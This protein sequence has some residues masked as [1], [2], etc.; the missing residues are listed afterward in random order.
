MSDLPGKTILHYKILEHVGQ[1]GMGVVYK[2]KDTKLDREVA[3][4]FLPTNTISGKEEKSRFEQEE[5]KP[6][7]YLITPMLPMSMRSTSKMA[8]P[9]SSWN[10]WMARLFPIRSIKGR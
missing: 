10:M 5:Q 6:L 3:L 4:K 2:A 8:R 1:G 7:P 9:S